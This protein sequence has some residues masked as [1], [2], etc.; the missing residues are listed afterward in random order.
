[1]SAFGPS[2]LEVH[3]PAKENAKDQ[4]VLDTWLEVGRQ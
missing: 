2:P 3:F 1:M 4:K